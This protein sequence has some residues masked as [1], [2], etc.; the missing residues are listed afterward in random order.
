M[1]LAEA[2]AMRVPVIAS[3]LPVFREIA[4]DIPDYLDPLDG[5]GWMARILE[6]SAAN[7]VRRASQLVR[8]EGFREPT[9]QQHFEVVDQFIEELV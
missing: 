5:P 9:W 1:P 6:Y 2:L 4:G 8:I 7:S 3:D